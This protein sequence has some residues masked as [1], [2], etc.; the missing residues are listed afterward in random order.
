MM[1]QVKL[2]EN[3][4][5]RKLPTYLRQV[6]RSTV[7]FFRNEKNNELDANSNISIISIYL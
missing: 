6:C 5:G 3:N 1:N 4:L 7:F 2:N